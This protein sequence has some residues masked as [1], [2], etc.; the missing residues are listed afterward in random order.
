MVQGLGEGLR[1]A[2]IPVTEHVGA[3]TGSE[4]GGCGRSKGSGGEAVVKAASDSFR[5]VRVRATDV[6]REATAF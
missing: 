1:V 3:V 5:L 2:R 4:T 6:N